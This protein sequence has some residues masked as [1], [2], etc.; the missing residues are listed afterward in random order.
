M[1]KQAYFH[2]DKLET[3]C[4]V[5][6]TL[7][8]YAESQKK[9]ATPLFAGLPCDKEYLTDTNNWVPSRVAD[10]IFDRM[11]Q[12]FDD[13]EIVYKAASASVELHSLGFLDYTARLMGDPR[14]VIKQAPILNRYF[15]RTEKIEVVRYGLAGATVRYSSKARYKITLHDCCYAKGTLACLPQIWGIGTAKIEEETCSVAIDKKGRINGKSYTIDKKSNVIEHDAA[16]FR[17]NKDAPKIIGKL[18][19]DKTF[20]LGKTLYGSKY[21]TYHISWCPVRMFFKGILYEIFTKPK[22]LSEVIEEMR[23][24]NDLIEEKYGELYRSNQKLQRHYVNTINALIRAIDAKDHYTED[25]SLNVSKIAEVVARELK[26]PKE[27]IE[28]IKKACKLHDLGKIGIRESILL[29][30][31]KLTEKEWQEIKKHP[32]LGAE[33]IKPLSFLSDVAVLVRQDHERWDGKG[34]PDGLKEEQIDIGARVITL[35]DAYDAMISGRP[36]RK[37]MTKQEAVEEVM[38]NAGTQFDPKVAE[39]FFNAAKRRAL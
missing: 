13:D 27:K 5:I 7:I 17:S 16:L 25:H 23:R 32:V 38:K 21:C 4:R 33:I 9:D 15:N 35:S 31:T 37:A 26:L 3:S 24:E 19:E 14:F 20:K 39:A 30:P 18:N 10:I 34:Y 29:K 11:R 1:A 2:N 28:T 22:V 6:N 12:M 36:Y 8:K